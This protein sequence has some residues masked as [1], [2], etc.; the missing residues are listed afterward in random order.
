V[1]FRWPHALDQSTS[2]VSMAKQLTLRSWRKQKRFAMELRLP[3]S[4]QLR[5]EAMYRR[6]TLGEDRWTKLATILLRQEL[7]AQLQWAAWHSM[8]ISK[9]QRTNC[10]TALEKTRIDLENGGGPR[11]PAAENRE[12]S[13]VAVPNA[14]DCH[15]TTYSL[16]HCAVCA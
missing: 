3:Q 4:A 5:W 11:R 1:H 13:K 6:S 8:A 2:F 12:E 10:R 9:L 16:V 15:S 14:S 7:G